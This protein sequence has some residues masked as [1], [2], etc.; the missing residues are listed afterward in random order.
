MTANA[1]SQPLDGAM[2][3]PGSVRRGQYNRSAWIKLELSVVYE[4]IHGN[5]RK[6]ETSS[7]P[8]IFLYVNRQGLRR[9]I[10]GFDEN[11]RKVHG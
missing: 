8:P 3:D 9:S 10:H 4:A 2:S 7:S 11:A 1:Y 5:R 6:D